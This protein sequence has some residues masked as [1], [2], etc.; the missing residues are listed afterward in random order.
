MEGEASDKGEVDPE[1]R[2]NFES[3]WQKPSRPQALSIG[4]G[5]V[6]ETTM[7]RPLR[8]ATIEVVKP[9]APPTV[10][11]RSGFMKCFVSTSTVSSMV[12]RMT[13]RVV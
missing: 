9:A 6:S 2:T 10:M 12:F 4:E 13:G 3:I 7:E 11:K 1:V 5:A 8:I